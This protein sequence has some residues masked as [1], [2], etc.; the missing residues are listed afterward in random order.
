MM[1]STQR[2]ILPFLLAAAV[3]ATLAAL[4]IVSLGGDLAE[5]GPPHTVFVN[6]NSFQSSSLQIDPGDTVQWLDGQAGGTHTVTQCDGPG[7]HC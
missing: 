1:P 2:A 3:A 6:N 4:A 7:C 5:A